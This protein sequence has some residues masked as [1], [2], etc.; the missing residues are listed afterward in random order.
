MFVG[1]QNFPGLGGRNFHGSKF[2]FI[3]KYNTN[4]CI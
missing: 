3:I 4:A 2:D 1:C